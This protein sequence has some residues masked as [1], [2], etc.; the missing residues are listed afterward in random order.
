MLVQIHSLFLW[1]NMSMNE[2]YEYK[3]RYTPLLRSKCMR[4]MFLSYSELPHYDCYSIALMQVL[5]WWRTWW[6][7]C[8]S[9]PVWPLPSCLRRASNGLTL[10]VNDDLVEAVPMVK[11]VPPWACCIPGNA[12]ETHAVQTPISYLFSLCSR[13]LI[14]FLLLSFAVILVIVTVV[15]CCYC[16]CRCWCCQCG[17]YFE[18]WNTWS[19]SLE[20]ELIELYTNP[21]F[22]SKVKWNHRLSLIAS[23]DKYG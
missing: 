12:D 21:E 17:T 11:V 8:L 1:C 3:W 19:N 13:Y 23:H 20:A 15:Y 2:N 6:S 7:T 22:D 9:L 16:C 5:H 10:K 18:S 4:W 14:C